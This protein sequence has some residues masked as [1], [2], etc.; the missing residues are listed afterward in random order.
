MWLAVCGWASEGDVC[1]L[2]FLATLHNSEEL[3]NARR[4]HLGE[5][6]E[7]ILRAQNTS[8]SNIEM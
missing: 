3:K 7:Y 1:C 8:S 5:T 4:H 6:I 2:H